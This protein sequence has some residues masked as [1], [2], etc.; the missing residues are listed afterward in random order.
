MHKY[1]HII[2]QSDGQSVT[3][4][5]NNKNNNNNNINDNDILARWQYD[6]G[7]KVISNLRVYL[8]GKEVVLLL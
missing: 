1:T 8:L 3:Q 2:Y 4:S 6:N 5:F 7:G